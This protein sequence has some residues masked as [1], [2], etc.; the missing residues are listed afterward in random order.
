L[1]AISRTSVVRIYR[2]WAVSLRILRIKK[3]KMMTRIKRAI[4]C[5]AYLATISGQEL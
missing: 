2:A 4:I 3:T 5:R 1:P